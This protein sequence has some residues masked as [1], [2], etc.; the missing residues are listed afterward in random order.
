MA[1][2]TPLATLL[3]PSSLEEFIGQKH[4]LS[5]T[6]SL[7]QAIQTGKLFSVIFWG[8]PGSGKTTLARIMAH[9]A[10]AHFIAISA[11]MA[12]IKDI[13]Q[14]VSDAQAMQATHKR[15]TVLFVDEVHRFNKAQQ[16][17]FLP[18]IEDGTFIFIG[19]TTE[20][21]SFELNNALLSRA[22]VAILKP[23]TKADLKAITQ[24]A[25]DLIK[26][27]YE[28]EL[29]LDEDALN[30]LINY[31]DGDAR[32]ILNS[33]EHILNSLKKGDSYNID[34]ECL[35]NMLSFNIRRF[36]KGCDLFYEQISALHKSVRGSNPD[37]TLYWFAR[38]IDG[39]CDPLYIARRVVRMASEDIGNADPR[40]LEIALNA[41]DV[42][43][44]LGSPEGE[45]ALAQ[46]LVY[47]AVAPKSNAVYIAYKQAL[48]DAET[49]GSQPVP[50]HLRN[51]PTSFM[52]KQGYGATYRYDHSEE[53]SIA[54]GQ[55][56]FP[57]AMGQKIYY[58]PTHNG[59]EIK[60]SE[61]L[62]HIRKTNK[63]NES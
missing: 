14:A 34:I 59:L 36:D 30:L 42:Q 8:P 13:R 31:A 1:L 49:Y 11:V 3:R 32:R 51:A 48:K 2:Y 37:A 57:E 40:G 21:P 61:K 41:W 52:K 44:R 60:I 16:D 22:D 46:A 29:S 38:M 23:H 4:L 24:R 43:Q 15:K 18:Y 27:H 39:G 33:F 53:D 47:L 25:L 62:S 17:A 26:N 9:S 20:N 63:K 10:Q 6:K 56:Y 28:I 5:P 58:H 50:I 7:F 19:A 12:G 55:T 35:K 54:Y 45:L